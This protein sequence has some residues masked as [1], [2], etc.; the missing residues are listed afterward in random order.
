[1]QPGSI[2]GYYKDTPTT[3][4]D[5]RRRRPADVLLEETERLLGQRFHPRKDL[6]FVRTDPGRMSTDTGLIF[7]TK[8]QGFHAGL[9]KGKTA[10]ATVLYVGDDVEG[11]SNGDL[12]FF[13]RMVFGWLHAF[14][15]GSYLGFLPAKSCLAKEKEISCVD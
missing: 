14:K 9:P 12:V 3:I 1:M 5:S 4:T 10:W 15:D 13:P 6:I 2:T 11:I 8:R 7:A